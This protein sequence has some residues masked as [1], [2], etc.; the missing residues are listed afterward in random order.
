M[1]MASVYKFGMVPFGLL[2]AAAVVRDSH[3]ATMK[4]IEGREVITEV[5]VIPTLPVIH[6][7]P[8]SMNVNIDMAKV[9]Y[10]VDVAAQA[11]VGCAF[12]AVTWPISAPAYAMW[13]YNREPDWRD[14]VVADLQE[15]LTGGRNVK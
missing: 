6:N 3:Q 14:E 10:G 9:K 13:E 11:A 15:R 7:P 1:S 12:G 2:G 8:V 4:D 5:E